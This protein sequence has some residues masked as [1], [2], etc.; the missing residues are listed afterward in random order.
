MGRSRLGPSPPQ[1][2]PWQP[3]PSAT[4]FAPGTQ[5][6][7]WQPPPTAHIGASTMQQQQQRS[8]TPTVAL[9]HQ[10]LRPP[11]PATS[12]QGAPTTA[13]GVPIHQ[14][15]FP[16][17]PPPLPTSLAGSLEPVYTRASGQPHVLPPLVPPSG[18]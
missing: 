3:P 18:I 17:S 15:R 13:Q 7:S 12:T 16:P 11:P 9:P 8:V 5:Q 10:L 14:V 1:L 6:P 4:P 2:P